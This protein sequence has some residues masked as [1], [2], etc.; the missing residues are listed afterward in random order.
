VLGDVQAEKERVLCGGVYAEGKWPLLLTRDL[1]RVDEDFLHA[2][3]VSLAWVDE[4]DLELLYLQ[5]TVVLDN[6]L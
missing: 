5:Q 2:E 4:R 1:L 6:D 3:S